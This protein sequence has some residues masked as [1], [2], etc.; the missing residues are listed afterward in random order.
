MEPFRIEPKLPVEAVQTYA[1]RQPVQTHF[2]PGTCQEA[3]C[4]NMQHGWKTV[5]DE[6]TELGQA[7]AHY[8]RFESGRRFVREPV[9]SDGPVTY[10]FEAGQKCFAQHQIS[11][12]REPLF[13]VCGGDW[14]G[15]PRGETRQHTRPEDWV[16]E[17]ANH[18]QTLADRLEQG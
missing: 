8:I 3:R 12:E 16:D 1:I 2:R 13:L 14:R 6:S 7:Q 4:P 11:L 9:N 17:F 18:Q 15:N 5:I 10:T